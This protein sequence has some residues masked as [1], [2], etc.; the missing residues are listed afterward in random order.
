MIRIAEFEPWFETVYARPLNVLRDPSYVGSGELK[1]ALTAHSKP[2]FRGHV[3]VGLDIEKISTNQLYIHK[4]TKMNI[5]NQK[6]THVARFVQLGFPTGHTI[7]FDALAAT[8]DDWTA[9]Y[10][11]VS[12][13]QT[14]AIGFNQAD[15]WKCLKDMHGR[16]YYS[17]DARKMHSNVL[18]PSILVDIQIILENIE[19]SPEKWERACLIRLCPENKKLKGIVADALALDIERFTLYFPQ[20]NDRIAQAGKPDEQVLTYLILDAYYPILMFLA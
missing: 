11:F 17:P 20:A 8:P 13:P 16:E 19:R 2:N 1:S 5:L 6:A 3:L 7:M 10:E 4:K 14:I 15:D 12:A 18:A 9:F